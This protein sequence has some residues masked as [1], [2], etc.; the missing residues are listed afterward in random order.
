MIH[1]RAQALSR[2]GQNAG[3]ALPGF[4]VLWPRLKICIFAGPSQFL[5]VGSVLLEL[6]CSSDGK[7]SACNA[8]GPWVEK[9]PWRREWRATPVFLPGRI[10]WTEEPGGLPS[11]GSQRVG[12]D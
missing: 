7:E 12:H 3:S 8:G 6:P 1:C 10:P 5:S 4:L 2:W 9:I 11:M